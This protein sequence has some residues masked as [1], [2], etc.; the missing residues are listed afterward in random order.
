M[1][2][3]TGQRLVSV[4]IVRWG[5]GVRLRRGCDAHIEETP[6]LVELLPAMTIAEQPVVADA[7]EPKWQDV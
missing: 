2:G 6:A 1:Q 4:S 3:L 5:G 7:V